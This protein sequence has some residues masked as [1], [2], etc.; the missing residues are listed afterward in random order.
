M[1]VVVW[2]YRVA[3]GKGAAFEAAYGPEGP[4]AQLFSESP[5]YEGT[6]LLRGEA[7][8][9]MTLDRW[10][11]PDAYDSFITLHRAEYSRID[12]ECAGLTEEQVLVGRFDAI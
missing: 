9:W 5:D 2:R 6:D 11:T 10:M 1:M 8:V 4:W 7:G 12:E 3:P